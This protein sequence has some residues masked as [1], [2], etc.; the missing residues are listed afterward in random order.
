MSL[1]LLGVGKY[2]SVWTP[3]DLGSTVK[4]WLD[5]TSHSGTDGSSILTLTDLSSSANNPTQAT[6]GNRAVRRTGANGK[7]GLAV[8][9]FDGTN[10]QYDFT[11]IN[12]THLTIAITGRFVE[13][14]SGS[15]K[16]TLFGGSV[17]SPEVYLFGTGTVVFESS[18]GFNLA[19]WNSATMDSTWGCLIA[20]FDYTTK[21][22]TLYWNNVQVAQA[23][24][25]GAVFES[26]MNKLMNLGW[27]T[28]HD[29]AG[30]KLASFIVCDS[31]LS[32]QNITNMFT[33]M[34]NRWA[35]Y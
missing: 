10:D 2:K 1:T 31:V 29:P 11:T 25:S 5:D 12:L 9:E 26:G 33:Y 18:A 23:T 13:G 21:V 22:G 7:N 16:Y 17:K 20:T 27:S 6:S 24:T 4:L 35:L 34:N 15:T 19:Q 30:G 14:T 3:S 8:L 28:G 32:S